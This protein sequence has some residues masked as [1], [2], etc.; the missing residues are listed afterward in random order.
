MQDSNNPAQTLRKTPIPEVGAA[1]GAADAERGGFAAALAMI[2]QLPLSDAEKAE[3][4][5]RLL[6]QAPPPNQHT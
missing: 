1:K 5:R 3:T 4:V 2:A 6:A